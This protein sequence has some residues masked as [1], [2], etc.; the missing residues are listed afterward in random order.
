MNETVD[1]ADAGH[2]SDPH[3]QHK[4]DAMKKTVAIGQRKY[5]FSLWTLTCYTGTVAGMLVT[6][7][8][9]PFGYMALGFFA[10]AMAHNGTNAVGKFLENYHLLG[11]APPPPK[12]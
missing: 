2:G 6:R 10:I 7:V 1:P 3:V 11:Q 8:D 4:E 5:R 12:A 9:V